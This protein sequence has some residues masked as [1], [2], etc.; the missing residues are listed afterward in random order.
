LLANKDHAAISL[1]STP[2]ALIGQASVIDGDTIEINGT[3]IRLYGIDAPESDQTCLKNGVPWRCGQK[4]AVELADK[5]SRRT[6]RCEPKDQDVYGRTVAVCQAGGIDLNAWMASQGWAL[7]YR[8]YSLVYVTDE[9]RA[10]KAKLG[11]WQGDFIY[12]W[13]WRHDSKQANSR[14]TAASSNAG[15][16]NIK[17]NINAHGEHI[18]HVPGGAYY[19]KTFINP[20]KGER[21]FCSEHEA[22]QAGWR[23]SKL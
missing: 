20:L 23:R 17:G 14:F 16:C 13:D 12:P 15:Q 4:A 19:S 2:E 5:I 3:R 8:Q 6:V 7:A 21:W 11:V 1:R 22:V 9:Q 10:S 18:Y